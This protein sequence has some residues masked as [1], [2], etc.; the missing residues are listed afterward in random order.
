MASRKDASRRRVIWHMANHDIIA[1]MS[2][3]LNDYEAGRVR[4]DDVERSILFNIE[5]LE[6][7]PYARITE[8]RLLCYRLVTAHMFVGDEEFIGSDDLAKVLADFR[9]F[10]GSLPS[11]DRG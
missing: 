9:I 3:V 11:G 10:L 6:A 4:P 2:A 5:A 1:R 8:A 7:L